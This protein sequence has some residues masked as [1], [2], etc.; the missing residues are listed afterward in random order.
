MQTFKIITLGCKVNQCESQL[1]REQLE[2]LGLRE[3]ATD[4]DCDLCIV[5]TCAVTATAQGKS[6]RAMRGLRKKYPDARIAAVGC[7]VSAQRDRYTEADVLVSQDCKQDAVRRILG[8]DNSIKTT[9]AFHGHSRA[10]LKIQDGCDSYC[11]Y[12]IVP[13]LRGKPRSKPLDEIMLEARDIAANGYKELVLAGIHLGFYGKDTDGESG[14]VDVVEMLL[15]EGLFPRLRLS[16]VEV[17]EVSDR[18]IELIAAD[19][20]LCPHLHMPLQSGSAGVLKDMGRPYTPSQYMKTVEKSREADSRI[21]ITTDVIVGFPTESEDDFAATVEV[22]RGAGFSRIH[23]F[24][25]SRREGTT[26]AARWKSGGAQKKSQRA[27]ALRALGEELAGRYARSFEGT[28]VRVLAES[29]SRGGEVEG[30]TDHYIRARVRGA[31]VKPGQL[32]EGFAVSSSSG[33]LMVEASKATCGR[34]R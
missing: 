21:A 25:Y 4:V 23:V 3:A 9:S 19:N 12:C 5:N 29:K 27:Q 2:S 7:G 28:T 16:G 31:S 17:S 1:L 8:R 20:A 15:E 13:H 11:S 22:C 18:L 10:F 6:V 24:P 14:L 32:V 33:V 26:A 30:Y 34:N